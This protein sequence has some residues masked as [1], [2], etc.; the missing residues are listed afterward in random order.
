MKKIFITAGFFIITCKAI[1]AQQIPVLSQYMFN[2][3]VINPAYAGSKE[4]VSATLM[5]R[6]QWAGYEGSPSTQNA[7]IHGR[8]K[9]KNIG[10]GLM[11]SSDKIGITNQTDV[12][13]S[14]GYHL[15]LHRARLSLGLQGGVSYFKSVFTELK[16]WDAN[17]PVYQS[18]SLTA[19][20][21]NFG[22]GIYYYQEK[23]YAGL[24]APF[25]ISY[26]SIQPL[27][28][29]KKTVFHQ[30]RHYY[31]H[32]GYVFEVNRE[33]IIRPS[34]LVKYVMHAPVQYDININF[35]L[36]HIF[37]VGGS[38]RSS[39]AL[40]VIFEY[41]VS[42]KLRIGYSFDYTLSRLRNYSSGSH[43]FMIGYD[44]G[45]PVLRIKTPRYF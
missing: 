2:G 31:L 20:Q 3:L 37:W 19:L 24:S 26:D 44:F 8:L 18:L 7:S 4:F 23:L 45:Y 15:P 11:I 32:G 5:A 35:L 42:R 28:F 22:A 30:A 12:Y 1:Q 38:Y 36:S 43:E 16:Y 17:D 39:D 29:Y 10:L 40:V 13:A 6:K 33:F 41:Q 21:P 34:V 14:Y 9:K 25:L 27:N